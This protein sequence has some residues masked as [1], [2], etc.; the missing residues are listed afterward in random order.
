M[1]EYVQVK[2]AVEIALSQAK[3]ALKLVSENKPAAAPVA[4]GWLGSVRS[5]AIRLDDPR[6]RLLATLTNSIYELEA[7]HQ[8]NERMFAA[9]KADQI[10][11]GPQPAQNIPVTPVTELGV[12]T[13]F[14]GLAAIHDTLTYSA[15]AQ[16]GV[17]IT[18]SLAGLLEQF[19]SADPRYKRVMADVWT[20]DYKSIKA[21]GR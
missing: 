6:T 16:V 4:P 12:R 8:A 10:N 9:S 21:N 19:C 14:T 2:G 17:A 15:P 1:S 3:A 11:K 7:C 5:A 13:F 18:P 20:N